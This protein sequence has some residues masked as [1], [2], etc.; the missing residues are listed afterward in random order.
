MIKN[1]LNKL[2]VK[3]KSIFTFG[4]WILVVK[5]GESNIFHLDFE[6][7]IEILPPKDRF[8]ADPHCIIKNGINYIFFEELIYKNRKGHIAFFK[9]DKNGNYTN[10]QK[11]I[12]KSY[13]L[14]YPF[15][16][17]YNNNYYLI[18]ESIGNSTIELYKCISFPEKWELDNI[19]FNSIN[20]LDT[21]VLIYN[22]KIWLFTTILNIENTGLHLFYTDNLETNI[23]V[24]HPQNPISSDLIQSRS[25]GKIFEKD[26]RLYR[27]SQDSSKCYGYG[28]NLTEIVKLTETEYEEKLIY[29]IEPD[30]DKNII[31]THT[32][33][34]FSDI[35]IIDCL[36]MRSRS[37]FNIIRKIF[38]LKFI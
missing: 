21:T 7:F 27:P 38:S 25:A 18:P 11:I 33:S 32:F 36:K 1:N 31:R 6:N 9:M 20:A 8:W 19:L 4:Q 12:E 29:K 10:A 26:G 22:N 28:I 17:Y 23:W 13:H 30:W 15:I 3:V 34:Y 14:S 35:I 16:F 37:L 5:S 24:S 2:F